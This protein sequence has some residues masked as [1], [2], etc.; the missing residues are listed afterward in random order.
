MKRRLIS[1][2]NAESQTDKLIVIKNGRID[3]RM[4]ASSG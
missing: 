3:W 2:K 4:L 1:A